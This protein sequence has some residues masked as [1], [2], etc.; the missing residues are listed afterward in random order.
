MP[1]VVPVVETGEP[2][3]VGS[4]RTG[5]YALGSQ[6]VTAVGSP[7]VVDLAAANLLLVPASA[8]A[9][10]GP[11]DGRYAHGHADY[12]YSRRAKAC[13][14]PTIAIPGFVGTATRNPHVRARTLRESY[15]FLNSRLALP[16]RDRLRFLRTHGGRMWALQF[17][18][19]YVAAVFG[20]RPMIRRPNPGSSAE[21]SALG[22]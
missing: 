14:Y 4:V 1:Q 7:R 19:P 15:R 3:F 21:V 20:R 17:P 5:R 9:A 8:K 18:L 13:G 12:D 2:S 10:I 16:P 22:N 6:P 11:I